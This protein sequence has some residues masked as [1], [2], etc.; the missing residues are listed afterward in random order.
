[1]NYVSIYEIDSEKNLGSG[2]LLSFVVL[3]QGIRIDPLKVQ[4][5]FEFPAPSTLVQLQR[6]QGKANF[7]S[8]FV[9]HYIEVTKVFTH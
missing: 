7:L 6:I 1:M 4:E 2:Q 8:R 3:K 5:T 9:L